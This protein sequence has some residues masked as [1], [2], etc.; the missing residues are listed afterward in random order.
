VKKGVDKPPK[1]WYNN[2]VVRRGHRQKTSK[3]G[4]KPQFERR[5]RKSKSGKARSDWREQRKAIENRTL[6]AIQ[7]NE[8]KETAKNFFKKIE[9][10]T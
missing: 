3:H 6:R 8:V 1:V 5:I 4:E 9:K 2:K 10:K 7:W